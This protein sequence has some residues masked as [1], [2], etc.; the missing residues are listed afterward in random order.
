MATGDEAER[1]RIYQRM[2]DLMEESGC[3]RFLTNGV[4]PQILHNSIQPA[5]RPDGYARL[6]EFRPSKG[7]A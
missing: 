2:Q 5:F 3:Y 4:M 7:A 1:S 6:R